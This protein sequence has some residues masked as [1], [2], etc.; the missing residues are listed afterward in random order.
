MHLPTDLNGL[1]PFSEPIMSGVDMVFGSEHLHHHQHHSNNNNNNNNNPANN[2]NNNNN[3]GNNGFNSVLGE[4]PG[5]LV[6]TGSPNFVCSVL[7]AHWRSNKTLPVAFKVVALG[8]VKD[9]TKVTIAAGND[10]NFCAELRNCV[11]YM[12]NQVAKFSDLRFVGRSGR[13]K[14]FSLVI[15]V[16]TNPPQICTYQKAIK[17]TVDGPRE[18]RSKARIRIEERM[19]RF[20]AKAAGLDLF[21]PSNWQTISTKTAEHNFTLKELRNDDRRLHQRGGPLNLP[22]ERTLPDP[23]GEQR[24]SAQLAGLEHLRRSTI[25]HPDVTR[26]EPNGF[27]HPAAHHLAP[28]DQNVSPHTRLKPIPPEMPPVTQHGLS[29]AE[30]CGL[31]VLPDTQHLNY[32]SLDSR[33]PVEQRLPTLESRLPVVLPPY[34]GIT[35][36]RIPNPRLADPRYPPVTSHLFPPRHNMTAGFPSNTSNLSILEES[37]AIS[38]LAL[39]HTHSGYPVI[40]HRELFNTMTPTN[41]L[42]SPYLSSTSFLYPHLY[43]S[44]PQYHQSSFY[45]PPSS[46]VRNFEIL[47]HQMSSEVQARIERPT[48]LASPPSPPPPPALPPQVQVPVPVSPTQSLLHHHHQQQQ[49]QPS[50]ADTAPILIG[51]TS[52]T[53][54]KN[55]NNDDVDDDDDDDTN[56]IEMETIEIETSSLPPQSQPPQPPSHS[57]TTTTTDVTMRDDIRGNSATNTTTTS[58]TTSEHIRSAPARATGVSEGSDSSISVWRPY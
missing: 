19:V 49:Q 5:E 9:G 50:T 43:S 42:P 52:K 10:E 3:N 26:V 56:D 45:M 27:H 1:P 39:P 35:D 6:R 41:T 23:L 36:V 31:P 48:L 38:T 47:T 18:P 14:S 2:N 34:Q 28:I 20:G 24:Y 32:S 46:D 7:P 29:P 57:A 30:R 8:D 53:S 13:G 25:H 12:K 4:H 58:T 21:H 44:T 11:A 17:V 51:T 33:F 15:S 40:S 16:N 37:R 54:N 22:V 55:N